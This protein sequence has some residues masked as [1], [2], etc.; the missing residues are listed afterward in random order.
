LAAV[1]SNLIARMTM[2][3][4]VFGSPLHNMSIYSLLQMRE[5]ARRPIRVGVVGAGAT[6]RAIALQLGTPVPGIRLAAIANRTPA[7]AERAFREAAIRDWKAADTAREVDSLIVS[8]VPVLTTDAQLL[9]RSPEIDIVI[10]VTGTVDFAAS[11]VLDAIAHQKPAVMVNAELDSLVGPLLKAKADEA[12]VVLTH[13]DGDEPGVAMTLFRYVQSVG[14]RPVAAG[15]IKG[16]VDYYRTPATQQGFA[17]RNDQDVKKVTSFADATKL[18]METTVLANATGF[19]VGRRGMFGPACGYVRELAKLLP[20][21]AMLAG[22]IVDYSVGAA[23]H[24]GG[25]VVVHEENPYKQ[26]Q[27]AYYKLGDG[28]F[29]VFYTPFHL[30]HIQLP[31][32]IARAVLHRDPT[33]APSR[34]PSCEV[35]TIAKRDLKAGE[36]LD[37]VGG[38]CAYGLIEN[39]AVARDINA[40]PIAMS[41]DCV[42]LRDIAK[43]QVV[44]FDDVRSPPT[45]LIDRLWQEQLQRWPNE[46]KPQVLTTVEPNGQRRAKAAATT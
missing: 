15:N 32:T 25:F 3:P 11:V 24:T 16:M 46:R 23:P 21:D 27:L 44:G 45:R 8:G 17:E 7:H 30:P 28:P 10:E 33:V 37:G 1:E 20:A 18:S 6:G 35:M 42:L 9:T 40:L 41:E 34:G 36:R 29:Y 22:G 4:N 5:S 13:T 31:S 12:G 26:T 38:F 19:G 43:D 39:R 14:L 2:D